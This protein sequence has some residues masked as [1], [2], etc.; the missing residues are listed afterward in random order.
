MI[1]AFGCQGLRPDAVDIT[2]FSQV[3]Q[4]FQNQVLGLSGKELEK[5][6]WLDGSKEIKLLKLDSSGWAK[7]LSFL[8]E[9]DPNQPEYVGAFEVEESDQEVNLR[10]R[11][12][13]R[14]ALRK[15]SYQV[16]SEE[17]TTVDAIIHEDK[18]VFVYHKEILLNFE[19]G[20]LRQYRIEGFQKILTKDTIKFRI[21]GKI[22]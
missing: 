6:V 3:D 5:E 18:D 11:S 13:E 16:Q 2:S 15:F 14:S 9:I 1:L 4:L 12:E 10:L 22:R 19:G 20:L 17:I 21:S 8:G 7:E